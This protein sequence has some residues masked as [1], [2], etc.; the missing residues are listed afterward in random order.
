MRASISENRNT[1]PALSV[2]QAA[3]AN[4]VRQQ[5][6]ERNNAPMNGR[7]FPQLLPLYVE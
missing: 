2:Q 3:F 1:Y 4:E 7:Y 6:L 5:L